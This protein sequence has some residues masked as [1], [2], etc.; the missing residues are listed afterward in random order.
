MNSTK[1]NMVISPILTR[2]PFS[3]P[4]SPT[5]ISIDSIN[6][7]VNLHYLK[8]MEYE[9]DNFIEKKCQILML[10]NI[11]DEVL[12]IRDVVIMRINVLKRHQ[13]RKLL[14]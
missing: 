6:K 12:D 10:L 2:S 1:K 7:I 13:K 3:I 5:H 8:K 4:D 11:I 14:L 9:Y